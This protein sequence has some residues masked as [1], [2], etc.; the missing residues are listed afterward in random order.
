MPWGDRRRGT[1]PRPG[2]AAPTAEVASGRITE[3]APQARDPER[4]SVFLD[5]VFAF[6][7]PREVALREGLTVGDELDAE[8]VAELRAVDEAARA[9]SAALAFLS[10]RPRSEREVRDRLRQKGYAR[11]ATD[12]AVA[13][14]EG[15]RYLNDEDFARFWVEHRAA[16]QPR[17]RLLLEQGLRRKGIDRELVG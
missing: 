17:G 3:I 8:R 11:A 4:V 14:L 15:W 10:Y 9:T 13:K 2:A 7:L 5:G 1:A 6:G 12:A 16:N